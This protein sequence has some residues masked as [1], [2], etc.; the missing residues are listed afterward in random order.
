MEKKVEA[1]VHPDITTSKKP[2][3]LPCSPRTSPD[4][5]KTGDL[6]LILKLLIPLRTPHQRLLPIHALTPPINKVQIHQTRAPTGD[7]RDFR[8]DVPGRVGGAER[9]GT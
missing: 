2:A 1:G 5:K 9:L 3:T 7:N 8:G 6:L 4:K